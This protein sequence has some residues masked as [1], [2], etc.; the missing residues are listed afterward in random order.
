MKKG[1]IIIINHYGITPDMPGATKHYD[2]AKYFSEKGEYEIEFWMCGYNHVTGKYAKGLN[3]F[4]LQYKYQENGIKIVKIKSVPYWGS[5]FMRQLNIVLF[6]F[7]VGIKLFFS[8]GIKCIILSMPPITF[9]ATDAAYIRGIKMVA[10]VE[11]LWPLFI[12][13]MGM[14]NKFVSMYMEYF[15]NHSYNLS[16]A[17]EAVSN[18]MLEY[19]RKKIKDKNKPSWLAP[20]GVNLSLVEGKIDK[21]II[22][23]YKWKD[24][25]IV[26]YAG[27]HGKANDIESVLQTISIFEKNYHTINGKSVSFV[28]IGNGD[29][30]EFLIE[31][32]KALKLK[33]VFFEDAV[34]SSE[35]PKILMNANICLTN[36]KK[37]ES[38]KL[39]RPNKIF[40]YMAAKKPIL[41]GIW[42][43][44]S[45]VVHE[46]GAGI[47]VDFTSPEAAEQLYEFMSRSDLEQIGCSGFEYISKYGNRDIIFEDFYRH[48]KEI[49]EFG[50]YK[51]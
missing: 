19:V 23:H 42:G 14:K 46:A 28:F 20:L 50:K 31:L 47:Y 43:E 29:N 37:I 12:E 51:L 25:F 2:L 7:F 27:A 15:A 39:V 34:P 21:N 3:G 4:K 10:D 44:A 48:I 5:N 32:A 22:S 6:D 17:F 45:D 30:K 36:L 40:Q 13:D 24:D 8:S 18:G 9:F 11:D 26:I 35:I 33:N 49:L 38:F 41:C 16:T 1:K